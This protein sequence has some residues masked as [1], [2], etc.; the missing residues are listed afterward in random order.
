MLTTPCFDE[1]AA[2]LFAFGHDVSVG[3]VM[4]AL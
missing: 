1:L 4:K 2:A 3:D